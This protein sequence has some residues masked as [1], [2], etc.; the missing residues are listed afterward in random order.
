MLIV[1][2]A[3]DCKPESNPAGVF[4]VAFAARYV[5][6][7]AKLDWVTEWLMPKL[8]Q[9]INILFGIKI[10]KNILGE[11][12]GHKCANGCRNIW[13]VE[14][15]R[16]IERNVNLE[17]DLSVYLTLQAKKEAQTFIWPVVSAGAVGA[18]AGA[19]DAAEL[20]PEVA[21]VGEAGGGP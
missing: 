3:E 12:E 10:K 8:L 17:A 13:G 20:E 2:V 6:G 11:V 18:T 9:G 5:H 14:Y 21:V 15:E 16:L 1:K 7:S 19:V 4:D